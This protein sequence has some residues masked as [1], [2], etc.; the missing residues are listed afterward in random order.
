MFEL[1]LLTAKTELVPEFISL[2][3]TQDITFQKASYNAPWTVPNIL[4]VVKPWQLN[5]VL[6]I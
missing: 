4:D 6:Q 5:P 3:R 1:Y 2:V